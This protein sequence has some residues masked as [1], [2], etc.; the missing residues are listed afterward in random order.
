MYCYI[1]IQLLLEGHGMCSTRISR[2][3]KQIVVRVVFRTR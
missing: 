3:K 2:R 1:V